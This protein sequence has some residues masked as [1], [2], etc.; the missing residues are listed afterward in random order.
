MR[1][2]NVNADLSLRGPG[3]FRS[4]AAFTTPEGKSGIICPTCKA[5]YV[6]GHEVKLENSDDP[7][8]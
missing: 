8:E 3:E 7:K 2:W 1:G 5:A 6:A 4:C